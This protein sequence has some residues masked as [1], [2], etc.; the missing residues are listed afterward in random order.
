M[1]SAGRA[2]L[3]PGSPRIERIEPTERNSLAHLHRFTLAILLLVPLL[4]CQSLS[5]TGTG[6][7]DSG[8]LPAILERGELR[9]GI[10]GDL[11]PL[12]MKNKA[13]EIIGLEVDIVTAL[14]NAMGLSVEL[15]EVPFPD[16][17]GS[18]C[19]IYHRERR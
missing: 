4:G 2:A 7:G 9:V 16:L 8:R 15:V 17:I 6:A 14:A 13:G 3:E 19:S 12:N 5:A 10:S 18:F 1:G 11:P